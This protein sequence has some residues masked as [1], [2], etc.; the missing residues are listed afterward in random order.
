MQIAINAATPAEIQGFPAT[1]LSTYPAATRIPVKISRM[2]MTSAC[3]TGK[4]LSRPEGDSHQ[5]PF[6][7][8]RFRRVSYHFG[9]APLRELSGVIS[10]INCLA[11]KT[12]SR[13]PEVARLYYRLKVC[14]LF[15]AVS[16]STAR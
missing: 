15:E 8:K 13:I 11:H 14:S 7:N 6:T 3:I 1:G 16:D 4:I 10:W 2:M 5:K 12:W 9:L